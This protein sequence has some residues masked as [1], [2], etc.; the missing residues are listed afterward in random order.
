MKLLKVWSLKSFGPVTCLVCGWE[1][2]NY[3][4]FLFQIHQPH[5]IFLKKFFLFVATLGLHC[6]AR[7]FC[8]CGE[9]ELLFVVV[10]GLLIVVASLVV[11]HRLQARG[12]QQLQHVG[13]VVTAH[14]LQGTWA[15]V[16]V[17]RGLSIC[18]SWALEC[19]LSSCGTWAQSLRSMWDLPG[20]RIEHVFPALAGGFLTTAPPGKSQPCFIFK[21]LFL[22]KI[23]FNC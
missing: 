19:R 11:E 21:T 23:F 18:G 3:V 22:L 20:P 14:R 12:L 1:Q 5:F 16:V 17:V 7:A 4:N 13:S 6:C 10:C 15:S 2:I 9:W 8:I